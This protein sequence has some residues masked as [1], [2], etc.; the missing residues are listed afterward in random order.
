MYL[1]MD[2]SG[3]GVLINSMLINKKFVEGYLR[4]MVRFN[5]ILLDLVDGRVKMLTCV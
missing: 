3:P 1:K 5:V 4:F 2:N